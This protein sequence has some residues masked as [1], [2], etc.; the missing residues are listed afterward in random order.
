MHSIIKGT[1]ELFFW[2]KKDLLHDLAEELLKNETINHGD[3]VCVLGPRP[4]KIIIVC[5][6]STLHSFYSFYLFLVNGRLIS[7][8][9]SRNFFEFIDT[10]SSLIFD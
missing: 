6:L 5:K 4:F 9:F 7:S 3:I 10:H 2:N 1:N 8:T